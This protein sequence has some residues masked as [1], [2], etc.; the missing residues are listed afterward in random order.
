M[1]VYTKEQVQKIIAIWLSNQSEDAVYEVPTV[2]ADDYAE[3]LE[4]I[5]KVR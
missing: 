2:S 1:G 5:C 4:I 3:H